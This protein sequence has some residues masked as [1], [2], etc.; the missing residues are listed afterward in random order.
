MNTLKN[1]TDRIYDKLMDNPYEDIFS[2][3][4]VESCEVIADSGIIYFELTDGSIWKL[5]L[6]QLN[7]NP[8][9]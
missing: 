5:Q 7:Y 9:R 3:D 1:L 6:A 2:T 8:W 4:N